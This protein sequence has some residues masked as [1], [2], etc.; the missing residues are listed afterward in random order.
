MINVVGPEKAAEDLRE[1]LG[2]VESRKRRRRSRHRRFLEDQDA[3]HGRFVRRGRSALSPRG[4]TCRRHALGD[5]GLQ[6]IGGHRPVKTERAETPSVPRYP[7]R[8]APRL[9]RSQDLPSRSA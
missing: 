5:E 7:L 9:R 8:N 2:H 3:P 1:A 6:K 4:L